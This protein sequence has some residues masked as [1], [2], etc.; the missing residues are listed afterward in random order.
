MEITSMYG[1]YE[2]S[3]H[4][5]RLNDVIGTI[6][7]L[8][9]FSYFDSNESWH[10]FIYDPNEIG[11]YRDKNR[12]GDEEILHLYFVVKDGK[13]LEMREGTVDVT[14]HLNNW[15]VLE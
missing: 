5:V 4:V 1:S 12:S 15:N 2:H 9:M 10:Y 13:A 14:D 7:D 6:V 3:W 8:C 11:M